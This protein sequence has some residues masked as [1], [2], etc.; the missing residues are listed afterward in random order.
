M[1]AAGE[2][3]ADADYLP[4]RYNLDGT[5]HEDDWWNFQVDGY[6]TWLWALERHLGRTGGTAD[7]VRRRDRDRGPLPGRDR[8]RHLPRLVGGEPRPD[9]RH[10]PRR[11]LR[12][13]PGGR[14]DVC[15]PPRPHAPRGRGLGRLCRPDPD[16]RHPR[17]PPREVARRHRRRRV[18][19]RRRPRCTTP[20]RSTARRH[21]DGRSRSSPAWSTAAST[22]TRRTPSTAAASGRSSPPC[23]RCTTP[24]SATTS[25]PRRCSTG[26]SPP[27]TTTCCCPSRPSP[28]WLPSV[29]DEWLERWGPS[30]HPLLWSHGMFLA[31]VAARTPSRASDHTRRSPLKSGARSRARQPGQPHGRAPVAAHDHRSAGQAGPGQVD[32]HPPDVVEPQGQLLRRTTCRAGTPAQ[33]A[34]RRRQRGLDGR[35]SGARDPGRAQRDRERRA[36]APGRS[37]PARRRG[38]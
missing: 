20:S 2:Q 30:A 31:A 17:R 4:A 38:P 26:S 1:L 33:L 23:W 18:T 37:C 15:P 29:L 3:P 27:P 14:P 5:R 34:D 19:P 7:A 24:A 10:H 28:C 36:R 13:P 11:R 6:G 35:G 25:A 22:A 12:R 9:P 32:G 21:R 16:P 8:H